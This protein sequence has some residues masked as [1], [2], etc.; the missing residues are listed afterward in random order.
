MK[1]RYLL[2][3]IIIVATKL[4]A[5][6]ELNFNKRFV[7]SEDKWVVFPKAEDDSYSF[8]FIYIDSEAG[9]TLNYEGIFKISETGEFIPEKVEN[10][11]MKVR[12][13]PNNVLV[14]FI[15][16]NKF[17][18]LKIDVIPEWL[19]YY[20]INENSIERLYKWGYM[21]NGWNECSK[22]LTFLEKAEKINP[23]YKGLAV[24]LAFS[25]N[26][27]S[28]YDKAEKIL[29]EDIKVNSSDAY[30]IKEYIYTLIKNGKID[31]AIQQY[32]LAKVTIKDKEYDAEN[33]YN[34]LQYY[35]FQKD[36]DNFNK[37]FLELSKLEITNNNI[38]D[39]SE[40]MNKDFNN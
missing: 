38:K 21:Y 23:K 5:Q 37:W 27:L 31:K 24:E 18:E 9:L 11:N 20:K 36:K 10:A 17:K 34:I 6:N 39:Y 40:R 3:L 1:T 12:L 8:G 14:A 22:G 33:C 32:N 2:L 4:N 29:E 26:C 15:P 30:V 19:K 28:Q 16:E 35:Y 25:Y 7:E 13:M